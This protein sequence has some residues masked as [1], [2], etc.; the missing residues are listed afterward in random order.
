M[1]TQG[2]VNL[3]MEI[4]VGTCCSVVCSTKALKDPHISSNE[5]KDA[6]RKGCP[7]SEIDFRT[8]SRSGF[9]HRSCVYVA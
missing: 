3:D 5:P 4:L 1:L 7:K 9:L 2:L 6:D 8:P